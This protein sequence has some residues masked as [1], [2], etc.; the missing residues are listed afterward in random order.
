MINQ[1]YRLVAPKQ[2]RTDFIDEKLEDDFLIVLI[3]QYVQ[4]ISAI[5]LEIEVRKL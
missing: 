1:S 4:Q 5:I 3:C 2:I